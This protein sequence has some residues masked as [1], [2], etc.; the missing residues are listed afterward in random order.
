[1]PLLDPSRWRVVEPYLDR[2]LDMPEAD[3]A[4]WIAELRTTQPDVADDLL[5]LLTGEDA[6]ERSGFLAEPVEVSLA[7]MQLGAWTVER[8]LGAG[9][10]G[11]VWLARRTDGRYE[12]K[13]AIK[14]LNLALLTEAGQERFRREGSMLARL[15]HPGIARLLDAGVAASGQP[16]LVLEHVDGVAIDAWVRA[17]ALEPRETVRLFLE[18][19]EAVR[20]AHANLVVHRDLKPSN[21]LVGTDGHPKLLDFGI[22]KLQDAAG[23]RT[24]LTGDGA[25]A[26]TPE[27]AAPEQLHGEPATAAT[28]VYS[29]GVLLHVLLAGVH[30][31]ADRRPLTVRSIREMVDAT[32]RSLG[33]GDLDRVLAKA[34]RLAPA[35]RY[36]TSA[37]LGD[38]LG[39]WLRHEPV[40]ARP[41]SL[42]Y[43]ARKFARRNRGAALTTA[44]VALA[45][46]AATG[47]S[48][49]QSREA[50]RQRDAA[51][52]A[53]ERADAQAEFQAL[54][55][56]QVGE[57][58]TTM[59]EILDRGRNVLEN[60][61]SGGPAAHGSL[62]LQLADRYAEL[63]E[64]GIRATMVAR[65]ESLA[66][67][68]GDPVLAAE[69][70]CARADVLRIDGERDA[71]RAL[72][73]STALPTGEARSPES[74]V[75]C[76]YI[77]SS[78]EAETGNPDSALAA[79]RR[80]IAIRDSLGR[81]RDI[82]Y[83]ALLASLGW[84]QER[85]AR[86]REALGTV[87][88]AVEIADGSG[89]A[90]TASASVMRHNLGTAMS[91][92]GELA[93]A[94]RVLHQV[95]EEIRTADPTGAL[96]TQ[97][98]IHYAHTALM[99]GMADS[100]RKYFAQLADQAQRNGNRYWLGRGLFG[101]AQAEIVL[102]RIAD[103]RRTI[104]RY[105]P[106]DA[107]P[108]IKS[109]DDQVM[110]VRMLDAMLAHATG[111]SR[112]ALAIAAEMLAAHPG[113]AKSRHLRAVLMV[114]GESALA[115]G[116]HA[117]ALGYA[118]WAGEVSLRDSLA[119]ERS[120]LVGRARVLEARA[121][122]AGGDT[123][124]ARAALDAGIRALR[125]GAGPAHAFTREAES[126]LARV[127]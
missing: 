55:M 17:R 75:F 87:R 21:I 121:H 24:S 50:R 6:A 42:G 9:G 47:F 37:E 19:I 77:R 18:V 51:L 96:P 40:L 85:G 114:A 80:A 112:R 22:A 64:N 5:R 38:D 56:S 126:L 11:T 41:Q 107:D 4:G 12:G 7:G 23:H 52:L 76:L 1:M 111:D 57:R 102:G 39:R 43:R 45:L 90:N 46:V 103:A 69:S 81:T 116:D 29:L 82:T 72:L 84:A 94:E 109:S 108:K 92:M 86:Y 65:A 8:P 110:D 30:P 100:A 59:R 113:R 68:A 105:R 67:V 119:A 35:D 127:D 74:E 33:L 16:Y 13:A 31:F 14:L 124:A 106:L 115:T 63:G 66:A 73:A 62:F 97:P 93:E 78:L 49:A 79:A 25:G 2:A 71:A 58:A 20:H 28:D 3:R 34:M 44:A 83:V 53:R 26:F 32:P 125:V 48:L 122:L 101:L 15:A 54:L 98:L 91:H 99:L 95:L 89:L 60:H 61:Y 27:Y 118:R 36:A 120:A 10:M 104:E 70:S 123:S 117:R 88:R